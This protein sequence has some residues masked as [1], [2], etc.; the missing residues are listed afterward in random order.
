M[1]AVRVAKREAKDS[2]NNEEYGQVG[3]LGGGAKEG[4]VSLCRDYHHV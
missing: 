2:G 3:G 1:R 4:L